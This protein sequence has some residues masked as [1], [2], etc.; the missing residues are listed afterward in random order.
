MSDTSSLRPHSPASLLRIWRITTKIIAGVEECSE[1]TPEAHIF[2]CEDGIVVHWDWFVTRVNHYV[3]REGIDYGELDV[4]CDGSKRPS[5][6]RA[7]FRV[8]AS[9]LTLCMASCLSAMAPTDFSST[10]SN[11]NILIVAEECDEPLP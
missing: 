11:G 6:Q 5:L 4:I 9:T 8:E 10:P 7:I 2:F 3:A 1:S